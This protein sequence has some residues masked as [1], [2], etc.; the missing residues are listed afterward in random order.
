VNESPPNNIEAEEAL[1]GALLIDPDAIKHVQI[2]AT[3]FYR[4]VNAWVYE[5]LVSL[6]NNNKSVDLITVTDDL[7]KRGRLEDM[8]GEGYLLGLI[9]ASPTSWNAKDY[10]RII[11]DASGRRKLLALANMTANLAYDEGGD[12]EEQIAASESAILDLST[13]RVNS[14]VKTG[15]AVASEYLDYFD[16]G[17]LVGSRTGYS[18]YDNFMGGGLASPF[19][20]VLAARPAMG[21]S[22]WLTGVIAHNLFIEHK[23]V[24]FFSLEMTAKQMAQRLVAHETGIDMHLLRGGKLSDAAMYKVHAVV[25]KINSSSLFLDE[26]GGLTPSQARAKVARIKAV[27][28]LD[29]IIYDHLHLMEPD[30]GSGNDVYDI[31]K[32]TKRLTQI[33]KEADVT[34][35]LAAQLNR[36]LE[37][38]SDKRP[39]LADLRGSGAIEQD[40]YSVTFLYRDDYYDP[41]GSSRKQLA[42]NIVA[43]NRDGSVGTVE[44]VWNPRAAS[45]M[46][47]TRSI[48]Q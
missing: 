41:M 37:S 29:L 8:G 26:T 44:L 6:D 24:L 30:K 21:K 35:I 2:E 31:A 1:L 34:S 48:V 10:A 23:R 11:K 13:T 47:I 14:D 4:E 36:S 7:R 25:D 20:H 46:N 3:D 15:K 12:L 42:E 28:G 32:I 9:N 27:H 43:K 5:S 18:E 22:A 33:S 16:Q 45:F 39:T 40:A 17:E 38:R 19:L